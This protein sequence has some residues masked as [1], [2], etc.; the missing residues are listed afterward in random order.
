MG[1]FSTAVLNINNIRDIESDQKAGKRSIPVRIGRKAAV[2]YNWNLIVG[3]YVLLMIFILSTGAYSG[4]LSILALAVMIPIGLGVQKAKN[5]KE[6]DPFLKK[7]GIEHLALGHPFGCG[8]IAFFEIEPAKRR[9]ALRK[10]HTPGYPDGSGN[11]YEI[12]CG[13]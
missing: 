5:P 8:L 10:R 4:L 1:C 13:L 6:T 2:N 3:G 11:S 7:N 12:P 9:Q